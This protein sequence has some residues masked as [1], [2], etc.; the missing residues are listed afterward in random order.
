VHNVWAGGADDGEGKRGAEQLAY[1]M[2][3]MQHWARVRQRVNAWAQLGTPQEVLDMITH[4]V[5]P[6]MITYC[7]PYDEG[8]LQLHGEQLDAW[9]VLRDKYLRLGAIV[10][11]DN[12]R[13]VN[14]CFL[15]PKSS[16][17]YR[18]IVDNR[19][20]N[21]HNVQYPTEL[22]TL[23]TLSG[24]LQP[25]DWM[26]TFDLEDGYFHLA[27]HVDYQKCFGFRVN[28]EVFRMVGLPFGWSGSAQSFMQFTRCIRVGFWR[29]PR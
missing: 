13:W 10:R 14:K 19:S 1:Q 2:T 23:H 22:D 25:G 15:F 9:H 5:K 18:L 11:D 8:A 27:I 16:G 7:A 24:A 6:R 12:I 26:S 28:G 29:V 17:G 4:G 21:A 3:Y 20:F